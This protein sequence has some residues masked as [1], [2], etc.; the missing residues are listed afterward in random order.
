MRVLPEDLNAHWEFV[1][2]GLN[3]VRAIGREPWTADNVLSHLV[4]QRAALYLRDDGFVILE[5]CNEPISGR[6]YLNVW[7][8]WFQPGRGRAVRQQV[9][10][11]LDAMKAAH[12]AEWIQFISV[13][14]GWAGIEPDFVRHRTIW[15]RA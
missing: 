8:M 6:K 5:Q 14:D 2:K 7:V 3:V 4:D 9:T 13:R 10:E 11:W 15:R 1:E 12:S